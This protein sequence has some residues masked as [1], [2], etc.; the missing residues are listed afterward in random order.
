VRKSIEFIKR[1]FC[2]V[3]EI[4]LDSP[5]I[6][7]DNWVVYVWRALPSN[8]WSL[9]SY[10]DL[11]LRRLIDIHWNSVELSLILSSFSQNSFRHFSA[12]WVDLLTYFRFFW[13]SFPSL[14]IVVNLFGI[15]CGSV[16]FFGRWILVAEPK[17]YFSITKGRCI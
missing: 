2:C 15:F 1:F 14:V 3:F 13:N 11:C 6:H 4:L 16:R 17:Q 7:V 12:L 5:R 10:F 9:R 8:H